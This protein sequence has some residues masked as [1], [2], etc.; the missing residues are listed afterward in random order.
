MHLDGGAIC[1]ID[2]HNWGVKDAR[3]GGV[4]SLM[5]SE[6]AWP[7]DVLWPE[8]RVDRMLREAFRNFFTG[9]SLLDR[10]VEGTN[11]MRVE[12]YLEDDTC[13][14]RAELPGL[15]PDKDVE[16]SVADGILHLR[17]E[18]KERAEEEHPEGYRSEFH[19]GKFERRIRLPEGTTEADIKA[20]YKDGILEVR[21]PAPKP[22]EEEAAPTKIPVQRG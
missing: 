10:M 19:Y 4:M 1:V 2:S 16:I 13:V 21:V 22:P 14:I 11:M 18:R 6:S 9:E 5:K 20:S 8:E 7:L 3:E 15:D 17:A 12:E